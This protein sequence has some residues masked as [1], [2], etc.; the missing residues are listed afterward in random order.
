[1][2]TPTDGASPRMQMYLFNGFTDNHLT[3]TAPAAIAGNYVVGTAAFGPPPLAV[4][5]TLVDVAGAR[6]TDD[7]ARV[8][9]RARRSPPR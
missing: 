1:M 3:V 8:V 5:V 4:Q 6:T 7:V 2:F 9:A